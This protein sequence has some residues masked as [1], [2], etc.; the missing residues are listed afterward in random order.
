[1]DKKIWESE[2]SAF[3][4]SERKGLRTCRGQKMHRPLLK[5]RI[6][7]AEV[8]SGLPLT[9]AETIFWFASCFEPRAQLIRRAPGEP[10]KELGRGVTR[11]TGRF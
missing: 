9:C 3:V 7:A 1:M 5:V 2:V 11:S 4:W 10:L 6:E 8:G